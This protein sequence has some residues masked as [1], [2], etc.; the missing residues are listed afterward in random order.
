M[1]CPSDDRPALDEIE[2]EQV[3][4]WEAALAVLAGFEDEMLS[5]SEAIL[6]LWRL[7]SDG[8]SE[9]ASSRP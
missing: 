6:E 9:S 4:N 1:T 8:Q 7:W 2:I 3:P 5:A